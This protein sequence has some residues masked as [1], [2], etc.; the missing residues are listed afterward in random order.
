[1]RSRWPPL[2]SRV[3]TVILLVGLPVLVIGTAIVLSIGRARLKEVQGTRLSEMAEYIAAA[4]DAYMFRSILDAAVLARV[5]DIR[6]AAAEGNERPFDEGAATALDRKWQTSQTAFAER[7]ALLE[8][9]ASKFL[10][11]VARNDPVKRE[12]LVTDRHGRLVAAS[13]IT[14]DYF[15]A[16][17][18]WWRQ[19]FDGGR[20]RASLS[21]VTR[22]ES[23]GVYAFEVAVPVPALSGSDVAG[24]MKMVV[25]SRE[26]L[27]DV[28]GVDFGTSAEA[29]LVRPNGSIVFRRRPHTEADRFFA[30]DLMREQFETRARQKDT[31]GPITFDAGSSDG[32][33]RLVVLAPCQ[34]GQTYPALAW[35]VAL[36]VDHE[37][38][39][40]PFQSLM[41]YLMAAFAL[42]AIAVLAIALWL[43]LRLATPVL[44][45]AVDMHLVDHAYSGG[46]GAGSRGQ[47]D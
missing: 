19:A 21:D 35:F 4:V 32:T 27:A 7:S 3:L 41:W 11:D 39:L 33:P 2:N 43:S 13:G 10:A 26:M 15:Q 46:E 37:E 29:T 45:S 23:A 22:D 17:E 6:R 18:D 12:I 24:V 31:S 16:D 47:N 14:T 36:S 5:P 40:A 25:N 20:G 9:A 30:A 38:L 44:D 34:L 1:M 8:S 42:T 28:A